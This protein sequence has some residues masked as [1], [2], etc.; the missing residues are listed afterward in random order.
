MALDDDSAIPTM[1]IG[2]AAGGTTFP[3]AAHGDEAATDDRGR[4]RRTLDEQVVS[5][6]RGVED[7]GQRRTIVVGRIRT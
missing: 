1:S 3:S 5:L 2:C 6:V 7:V 4:E